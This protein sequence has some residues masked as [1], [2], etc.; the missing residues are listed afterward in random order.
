[1]KKKFKG[2]R[3][4]DP[5]IKRA[6]DVCAVCIPMQSHYSLRSVQKPTLSLLSKRIILLLD[7]SHTAGDGFNERRQEW[8]AAW[9]HCLISDAFD[10]LRRYWFSSDFRLWPQM[11]P[12]DA[13]LAERLKLVEARRLATLS[14]QGLSIFILHKLDASQFYILIILVRWKCTSYYHPVWLACPLSNFF[15]ILRI[16]LTWIGYN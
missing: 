15:L 1:M 9:P 8:K 10:V 13:S 16:A 5:L 7:A 4:C 11:E 6:W 12:L 14:M 2:H 3:G